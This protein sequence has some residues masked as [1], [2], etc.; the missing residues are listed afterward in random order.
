M[1]SLEQV[2]E[3]IV[4]FVTGR[5]WPSLERTS[6]CG[7]NP[8]LVRQIIYTDDSPVRGMYSRSVLV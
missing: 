5:R 2:G 3:G 1:N 7:G 6:K 8:G 4:I